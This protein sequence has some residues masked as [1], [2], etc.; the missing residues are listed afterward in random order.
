MEPTSFN[1]GDVWNRNQ[2]TQDQRQ[3][4]WSRRLST[5]ETPTSCMTSFLAARFNGADVFQRRRRDN[6]RLYLE[7]AG[8]LQWSRRLSTSETCQKTC[9]LTSAKRL[10]WSRRLSTSETFAMA[11]KHF[12]HPMLQWS[13]RLSTSETRNQQHIQKSLTTRFNGADVFQRRRLTGTRSSSRSGQG[14]QWSRRLSTSETRLADHKIGNMDLLQWSRRLSTSETSLIVAYDTA[15][16]RASMEPTSFNVGDN[17]VAGPQSTESRALQWSRRLSTSETKEH[18][19]T[20]KLKQSASMEPTSFNVGDGEAM[21]NTDE[22]NELQWSRR[23]STSE[24][25]RQRSPLASH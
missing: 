4:Q 9:K 12:P 3:L 15:M 21:T 5:S 16:E 17:A 11:L 25:C 18:V 13:R 6:G 14:L 20:R 23:L 2:I 1:V 24:T 19:A 8:G 22:K 7:F 10:Q